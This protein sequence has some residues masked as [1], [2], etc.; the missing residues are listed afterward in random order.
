MRVVMSHVALGGLP[1]LPFHVFP[2]TTRVHPTKA[3]FA[4]IGRLAVILPDGF[5]SKHGFDDDADLA[6]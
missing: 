6:R 4:V 1:P 3:I 2:K 5:V